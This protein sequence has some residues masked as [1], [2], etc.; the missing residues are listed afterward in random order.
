MTASNDGTAKIWNTETGELLSTLQGH[1]EA[2]TAVTIF[3]AEED[4][5]LTASTDGTL[6]I[7]DT[8]GNALNVVRIG[9]TPLV[10]L[11]SS[12]DGDSYW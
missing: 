7:W 2:V 3:P 5:I 8:M 11:D 6:R 4:R 1:E 12:K 9:N 10:D